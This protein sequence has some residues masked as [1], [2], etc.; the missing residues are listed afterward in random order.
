MSFGEEMN[1]CPMVIN[2]NGKLVYAIYRNSI[3]YNPPVVG[4]DFVIFSRV[5]YDKKNGLQIK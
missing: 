1:N 4:H 2:K 3:F 5:I